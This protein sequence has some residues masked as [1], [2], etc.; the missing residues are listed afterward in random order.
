MMVDQIPLLSEQQDLLAKLVEASRNVPAAEREQFIY[1]P[2]F[3]NSEVQHPGLPAT[4]LPAYAGDL[5]VLEGEGLLNVAH[6]Q[7]GTRLFDVTPRGFQ[8]Y[9]E[10]RRHAD[11]PHRQ[12]EGDLM[13]YLDSDAFQRSYPEAYRKWSQAAELLWGSDS[14][15][16]LTM[17]GHLCREAM[18]EF[19]TAL[20]D[21][22]Q[23][24]GVDTDKARDVARIRA[25]LD[26]HSHG[27][28]R[29]QHRSLT[30]S[31]PIGARS[32]TSCS[33][34][35]TERRRKA[36]SSSGRTDGVWCSRPRS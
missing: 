12:V 19:A 10:L 36:A 32:P 25:V 17:V 13:R 14:E 18:Q 28:G 27:S 22:H 2:T 33:A 6:R 15:Q 20:V 30:R 26:Q 31:L 7:H 34:K 1:A 9:E 4:R 8:V 5:D 35:S 23:P 21:R 11:T 16:Q 24:P 29:P 3:G